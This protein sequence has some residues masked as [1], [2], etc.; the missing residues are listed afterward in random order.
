MKEK[1]RGEPPGE[2]GNDERGR[3]SVVT[4]EARVKARRRL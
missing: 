3:E 2:D 4:G 1:E